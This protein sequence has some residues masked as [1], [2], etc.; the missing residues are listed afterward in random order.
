MHSVVRTL[1]MKEVS[2]DDLAYFTPC[3][4]EHSFLVEKVSILLQETSLELSGETIWP[5]VV[6]SWCQGLKSCEQYRQIS[7]PRLDYAP[8]AGLCPMGADRSLAPE[9]V[10]SSKVLMDR[11]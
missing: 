8:S 10:R 11:T 2:Q 9:L 5:K 1:C 4:E 7:L 6:T 3:L